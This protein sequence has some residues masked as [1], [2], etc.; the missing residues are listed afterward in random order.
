MGS[1]KAGRAPGRQGEW[2]G[3]L[4]GSSCEGGCLLP[5]TYVARSLAWVGGFDMEKAGV[6]IYIYIYT[7]V[8]VYIHINIYIYSCV[9]AR[10]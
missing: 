9:C 5:L 4:F 1:G 10:V 6:H 8:C 7:C 2:Y 3:R